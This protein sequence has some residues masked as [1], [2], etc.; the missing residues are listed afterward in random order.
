MPIATRVLEMGVFDKA[1]VND[2]PGLKFP[3]G[4]LGAGG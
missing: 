2:L 3:L 4:M 1:D